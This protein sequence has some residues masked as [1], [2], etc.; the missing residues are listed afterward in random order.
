MNTSLIPHPF[1]LPA[2]GWCHIAPLGAFRH[3]TSGLT[4]VI[5]AAAVESMVRR[6]D[7]EAAAP[8]FPGLLVDFD[9]FS[10]DP[11]QPS[12]AA[13]WITALK[14]ETA[15]PERAG[16]WARIRWSDAGEAAVRGGRYRL[17]SPVFLPGDCEAADAPGSLRPLRLHRLALTNDPNLNG[18]APLSNRHALS[19]PNPKPQPQTKTKGI[20]RNLAQALG[21]GP[22]ATEDLVLQHIQQ[23]RNRAQEAETRLHR[24]EQDHAALLS[25]QVDA[26]LDAHKARFRPESRDH[27]R[28]A[29]IANR[30]TAL[31]L[32]LSI[33]PGAL[34]G[35]A[36]PQH[37]PA[38]AC[39]PGP[40]PFA[41]RVHEQRQAVFEYKNRH[42]CSWQ[43]AWDSVRAQ[44]PELFGNAQPALP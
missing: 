17:V 8:N 1:T 7:L 41:T 12:A 4:Q 34:P 16:L 15:P 11:A 22:E 23:L 38:R 32:L 13:G 43:Q 5:D 37:D 18:L 20:M 3:A 36:A 14:S 28:S 19:E 39:T 25:S 27:W 6:F 24:L 40:N 35:A 44:R 29:L 9:H 21:L 31:Q 33:V 10:H 2:D 30:A 42:D 26:D